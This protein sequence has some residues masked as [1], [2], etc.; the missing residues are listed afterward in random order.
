M[1]HQ[2][3]GDVLTIALIVGIRYRF[4]AQ[5]ID[6]LAQYEMMSIHIQIREY[7]CSNFHL[8]IR[9]QDPAH[10]PYTIRILAEIVC[11]INIHVQQFWFK[12][13]RYPGYDARLR[14]LFDFNRNPQLCI[15]FMLYSY[16]NMG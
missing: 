8:M 11:T 1:L 4:T 12:L 7:V 5:E 16:H 6:K 3:A 15:N 10:L 14:T 9:M 2:Q 13:I